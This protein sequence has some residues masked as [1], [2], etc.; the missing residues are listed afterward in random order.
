M[1]ALCA[2]SVEYALSATCVLV[3]FARGLQKVLTS[4]SSQIQ[5]KGGVLVQ[6]K[7]IFVLG[8][9][10]SGKGTQVCLFLLRCVSIVIAVAML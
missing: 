3:V 1:D 2:A 4:D 6:H 7:V 5:A 9:P 10:G 8:G